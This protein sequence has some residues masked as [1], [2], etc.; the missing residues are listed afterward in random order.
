[1]F[2]RKAEALYSKDLYPLDT[3][4]SQRESIYHWSYA[5]AALNW[6][7]EKIGLRGPPGHGN[8]GV[9]N[10]R[11]V[12]TRNVEDMAKEIT[13]A[14]GTRFSLTDRIFT[15]D[16]FAS[17]FVPSL[18]ATDLKVLLRHIS[19][20]ATL[21]AYD[22]AIVKFKTAAEVAP[23][24][25]TEQ[26]TTIAHLKS[27]LKSLH[28]RVDTLSADISTCT[29]RAQAAVAKSNRPVALAALKSRK[30]AEAAL[31]HQV[32]ALGQVE[33]VMVSI[34]TAADNIELV[35]I[36]ERSSK[37]L[38]GLNKEMGGVERVDEI[39]E[40]LKQETDTVEEVNRV[41]AEAGTAVDEGEVEAELEAM[42]KETEEKE[43]MEKVKE[44][45]EGIPAVREVER[46]LSDSLGS[47]KLEEEKQEKEQVRA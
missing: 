16:L 3:F 27:L 28:A 30:S 9:I 22:G 6:G 43:R 14:M 41:L 17:E 12:V 46:Q 8:R 26:D 4:L 1:L 7:L 45:L 23:E 5:G 32:K 11:F 36:L 38:S 13:R 2:T 21:C 39:M 40:G 37:V 35:R 31:T 19:R 25:I 33:D 10:G 18:S 24:A 20:D 34:Q 29:S 47:M 44:Q 42:M 15:A